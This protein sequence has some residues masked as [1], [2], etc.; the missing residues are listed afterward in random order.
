MAK[1]VARNEQWE[2]GRELQE[3]VG[4]AIFFATFLF[5]SLLERHFD[6]LFK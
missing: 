2:G 1:V 5:S 4:E 6:F 3:N